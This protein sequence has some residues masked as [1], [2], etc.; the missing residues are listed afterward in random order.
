MGARIKVDKLTRQYNVLWFDL[1]SLFSGGDQDDLFATPILFCFFSLWFRCIRFCYASYAVLYKTTEACNDRSIGFQTRWCAATLPKA[2]AFGYLN[3]QTVSASV[4]ISVIGDCFCLCAEVILFRQKCV[5]ASWEWYVCVTPG[6]M[7]FLALVF[8]IC[9]LC[10]IGIFGICCGIVRASMRHVFLKTIM[11]T[12]TRGV[13][14]CVLVV[15]ALF[16]KACSSRERTVQR[17]HGFIIIVSSSSGSSSRN[18]RDMHDLLTH[19]CASPGRLH[20]THISETETITREWWC[21]IHTC[22]ISYM[23]RRYTDCS[24]NVT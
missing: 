15:V 12:R 5:M 10:C 21:D 22:S 9:G 7:I 13:R 24:Q 14:A 3:V 11:F 8:A 23:H 16:M 2:H 20:V 6:L 1:W 18:M 4:R 19:S 17:R